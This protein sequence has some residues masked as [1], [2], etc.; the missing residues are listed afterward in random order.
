[1]KTE[2]WEQHRHLT[3]KWFFCNHSQYS[4]R[5]KFFEK[6]E[7]RNREFFGGSIP[8]TSKSGRA[9]TKAKRQKNDVFSRFFLNLRLEINFLERF[10]W[11]YLSS[12][13]SS[14]TENVCKQRV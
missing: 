7:E 5:V 14:K 8:K 3:E 11:K 10:S 1:V 2:E 12:V 13:V 9:V 6:G 4:V